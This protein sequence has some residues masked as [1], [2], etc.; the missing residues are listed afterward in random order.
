MYKVLI[1]RK[2]MARG[3][4]VMGV[5]RLSA[6]GNFI[7]LFWL[8]LVLQVVVFG[9]QVALVVVVGN[10][11]CFVLGQ[12]FKVGI[13]GQ[14]IVF[15]RLGDLFGSWESYQENGIKVNKMN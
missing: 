14:F 12:L 6:Y 11:K 15:F 13:E 8:F 4:V 7:S 3:V 1:V 2:G 9:Y 10:F 5:F